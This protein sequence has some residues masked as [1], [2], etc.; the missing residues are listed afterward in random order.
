MADRRGSVLVGVD[1]SDEGYAAAR[2]AADEARR[3]GTGL[4]IVHAW[5]W[6]LFKVD[7]GPPPMAP[8]AGLQAQAEG[9]LANAAEEAR[10]IAAQLPVETSLV[11]GAAAPQLV[12]HAANAQLLV[13]GNRGLGG[14][15]GLLLGSVGV[16]VSEHAPCP[17][18]VVRGSATPGGPV[19][20]GVDETDASQAA[21]VTAFD[22]ASRRGVNVVV[23]HAWSTPLRSEG[24]GPVGYEEMAV[25]GRRAGQDLLEKAASNA[26]HMHP[27]VIYHLQLVDRSAAA[28]LVTASASA[29]LVVVGSRGVGAMRGLLLGST[30]H[31]LIHHSA[32]PVLV[33]R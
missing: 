2:W 15:T 30:A 33:Q 5:L 24:G 29:Q 7:L 32:C 10:D 22:E 21:V 17:V 12:R 9:I 6:P 13:V 14:F 23:M 31:A 28:E 20:V 11:T 25:A 4:N 8:G 16:E 26:S 19:V 27:D 1:G 3:L 18:V